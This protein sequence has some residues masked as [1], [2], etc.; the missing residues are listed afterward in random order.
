MEDEDIIALKKEIDKV[1]PLDAKKV[2]PLDMRS[3]NKGNWAGRPKVLKTQ[4]NVNVTSQMEKA[5]DI[6]IE[7]GLFFNRSEFI[8]HLIINYIED[9]KR[10]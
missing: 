1:I 6:I 9:L 5:I 10:C 7:S 8:R 4:I 3:Y 2:F